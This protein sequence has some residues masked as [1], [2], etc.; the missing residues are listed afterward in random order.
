MALFLLQGRVLFSSIKW[1]PYQ[2]HFL[3]SGTS[4]FQVKVFGGYYLAN[5]GLN[6]SLRRLWKGLAFCK[7]NGLI[8]RE[9]GHVF[10]GSSLVC[11]CGES[12][13]IWSSG[14]SLNSGNN[15]HS[16]ENLTRL[17]A[18]SIPSLWFMLILFQ[19]P[20][21]DS[22]IWLLLLLPCLCPP[23]IKPEF[24]MGV[25]D[26]WERDAVKIFM[27]HVFR[28]KGVCK[29]LQWKL[30][31]CLTLSAFLLTWCPGVC[32]LELILRFLAQILYS[33]TL[34]SVTMG[35]RGKPTSVLAKG[36]FQG[37]LSQSCG[38]SIRYSEF[39]PSHPYNIIPWIIVSE[40]YSPRTS[41]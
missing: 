21:S 6:N 19:F 10:L 39:S 30:I 24:W 4:C 40:D 13:L 5:R 25:S 29:A 31:C 32:C 36:W 28:E 26:L 7:G 9:N 27:K 41:I 11:S 17:H 2:D 34:P 33:R 1:F 12:L 38:M 22:V 3:S 37:R 18:D 35:P 23:I 16:Q 8:W 15:L 14:T 20:A